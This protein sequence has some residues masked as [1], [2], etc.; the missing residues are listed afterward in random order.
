MNAALHVPAAV[1]VRR[2]I[3]AKPE[4][5]FDAWLDAEAL[6]VWMRPTGIRHTSA[7]T[8]PRVGGSYEIIM[9]GDEKIYPHHG[10][11]QVIDRPRRLVFTWRSHATEGATSLVTVEFLPLGERTEVLLTHEQLPADA[12]ESHLKGWTSGIERLDAYCTQRGPQ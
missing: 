3:A 5:L 10:V 11:Y 6:A 2:T 12:H 4:E 1:V 7:K 8:E 9:Q